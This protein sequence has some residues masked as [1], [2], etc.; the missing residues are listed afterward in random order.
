MKYDS[1]NACLYNDCVLSAVFMSR[2]ASFAPC[3]LQLFDVVVQIML[4]ARSKMAAIKVSPTIFRR[5][6]F[7]S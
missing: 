6:R 7:E 5:W 2:K 1:S 4:C 3:K